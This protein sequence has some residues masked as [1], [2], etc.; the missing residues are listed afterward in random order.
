[1]KELIIEV[2]KQR[3]YNYVYSFINNLSVQKSVDRLY[4]SCD[5]YLI[6]TMVEDNIYFNKM[7]M[8]EVFKNIIT[9]D[10]KLEIEYMIDCAL[11]ST[12]KPKHIRY[13]NK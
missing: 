6:I 7:S 3:L 4:Y 10:N 8:M 11:E 13:Y 12:F 1:M 2:K 9:I 5:N